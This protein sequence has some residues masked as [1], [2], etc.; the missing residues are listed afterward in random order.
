MLPIVKKGPSLVKC[1][2]RFHLIP[3]L[4]GFLDQPHLEVLLQG[5]GWLL[6]NREM[7]LWQ[8]HSLY[9]F[10]LDELSFFLNFKYRLVEI[11]FISLIG[12]LNLWMLDKGSRKN[13]GLGFNNFRLCFDYLLND[14]QRSCWVLLLLHNL[15]EDSRWQRER[16]VNVYRI[17][18]FLIDRVIT[19]ERLHELSILRKES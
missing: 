3:I 13:S 5:F 14:D 12:H 17:L 2:P 19:E 9:Y 6:N 15:L 1:L 4:E 18:S 16:W 11:D 10:R 7:R 8:L